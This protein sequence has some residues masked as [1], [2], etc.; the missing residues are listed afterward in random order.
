MLRTSSDSGK[1]SGHVEDW[2][3][4]RR[5]DT[6]TTLASGTTMS[7]CIAAIAPSRATGSSSRVDAES[8]VVH[9]TAVTIGGVSRLVS[10]VEWSVSGNLGLTLGV[11]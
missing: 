5:I 4:S 2:L 6:R 11:A 9:E 3:I 8:V 7:S 10:S 1:R